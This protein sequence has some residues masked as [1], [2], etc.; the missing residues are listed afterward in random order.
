MSR[1]I[2]STL[3]AG[4]ALALVFASA[5]MAQDPQLPASHGSVT[6]EAGFPDD[7]HSIGLRAGGAY[8]AH[9]LDQSCYGFVNEAP[10]VTLNYTAGDYPLY[11]SAASDTDTTMMVSTPDGSVVCDDDSGQGMFDPGILI[12]EPV[13]GAYQ[14]W[15]GTYDAGVGLPPAM[16]HISEVD[17]FADNPFSNPIR[18]DMRP[19]HS[20]SLRAGFRNDPRRY[21][22]T[23]GGD[24]DM[25]A[26]GTGCFG[27][28]G[29]A[30]DLVVDYRAG[31]FPL[32]F[33]GEGEFDG[34]LAVHTP[35]GEYLCDD[36]SAGDLDPGIVITEPET[37]R[38]AV[39]YG[40]LSEM[41][42]QAGTLYVSELGFDGVD[43]RL[44]LS[45]PARHGNIE[46]TG[47]FS[48]DPYNM[49]IR[50]GGDRDANLGVMGQTV[51]SG[52][53][54]GHVTAEPTAELRFEAGDLPLY[55]SASADEDLTL[56]VNAPDGAWLCDDDGS[57]G[58]NPGLTIDAPQSGVYDIY[59]GTYGERDAPVP[60]AL[61]ISELGY[62]PEATSSDD[63]WD[64]DM[65]PAD[66]TL[67]ALFGDHTLTGGFLPDPYTIE[68]TA[69]GPLDAGTATESSMWC[70][71]Y[72]TQAPSVELYYDGA[73]ELHIYATSEADT[74]LA[75][76]RPDGSWVCDDDGGEGLDA[77]L[78]FEA[79]ASGIYDIYVG[80]FG[81]QEAPATLN[82]SEIGRPQD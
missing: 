7:P 80:T 20:A 6:L 49:D 47:G 74:T 15:V 4:S 45:A 37:G 71:G 65:T 68:L 39:W 53:C 57:D 1:T 44:D 51:A 82:I 36:D 48:P 43:T 59:V 30:P 28:S 79:D 62:G 18:P 69:G 14:I 29:Q 9:G 40:T 77:G 12:E 38:Y 32:F 41:G 17:F 76:N 42:E 78:S 75:V 46:L 67:P 8:G 66:I 5:A 72:I 16:L 54:T 61:H 24:I 23:A 11:L 2:V 33:S 56:L 58:L 10:N 3:G 22:V 31:D 35:S 52:Y 50:A 34:T 70:A 13:S 60:A 21:E 81:G 27:Y 64:E 55:I 26:G 19:E 63:V 25:G 73:A